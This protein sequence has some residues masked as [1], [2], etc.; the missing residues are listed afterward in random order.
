MTKE[1]DLLKWHLDIFG[2]TDYKDQKTFTMYLD[3]VNKQNNI[4]TPKTLSDITPI[5]I[6][7]L[8]EEWYRPSIEE[9]IELTHRINKDYLKLIDIYINKN[10]EYKTNIIEH[11][12]TIFD[13]LYSTKNGG[14]QKHIQP[15]GLKPISNDLLKTILRH[16]LIYNGI[17]KGFIDH[18]APKDLYDIGDMYSEEIINIYYLLNGVYKPT[19]RNPIDLWRSGL[20]EPGAY[21]KIK[22][23][24]KDII[25][26]HPNLIGLNNIRIQRQR[27]I[28]ELLELEEEIKEIKPKNLSIL[29]GITTQNK[30]DY[31]LQKNEEIC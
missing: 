24:I 10:E 3:I 13:N 15:K 30:I 2:T 25:K 4:T 19:E 28:D 9:Y 22:Y 18:R 6:K 20:Y 16:Y 1:I 17:S 12:I 11:I 5:Q 8:F 14:Y 21:L 31:L 29:S 26:H 7:N 27:L 23:I